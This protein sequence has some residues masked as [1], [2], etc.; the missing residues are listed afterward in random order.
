MELLPVFMTFNLQ[1]LYAGEEGAGEE[2][3]SPPQQRTRK[4]NLGKPQPAEIRGNPRKERAISQIPTFCFSTHL[5]H[6]IHI[7]TEQIQN[8]SAK[9]I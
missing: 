3:C 6:L 8:I 7:Y 1:T 4:L 9:D 5:A 2:I